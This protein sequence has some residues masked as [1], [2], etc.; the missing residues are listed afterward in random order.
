LFKNW[1]WI[2]KKESK[3]HWVKPKNSTDPHTAAKIAFGH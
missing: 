2:G 3:A 1:D